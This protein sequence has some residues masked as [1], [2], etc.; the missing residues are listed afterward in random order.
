MAVATEQAN[1]IARQQVA[2]SRDQVESAQAALAASMQPFI[3]QLTDPALEEGSTYLFGEREVSIS[4]GDVFVGERV[5]TASTS[6]FRFET[7]GL[8]RPS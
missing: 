4:G 6:G 5:P 8:A 2:A 3:A 1:E 7:R